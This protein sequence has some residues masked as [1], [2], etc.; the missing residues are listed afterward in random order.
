MA[1]STTHT[2]ELAAELLERSDELEALEDAFASST[3][4]GCGRLMLISGEAGVGKTALVRAFCNEQPA[5]GRVLWGACD[6]LFTPR[7]LGPFV[8][9][10]AQA[11]G[12]LDDVVRGDAKPYDVAG[13]VIREFE[14][15]GPTILVL[16]DLHWADEATLDVLTLLGR[17]IDRLGAT[18]VLA[19]YRDDE[20]VATHPLRIVVGELA[21]AEGVSALTV[22]PLSAQAVSRLAEPH[23]VEPGELHRR[24]GGN[25]F[26]VTEVL[27]AGG[28]KIP[29]SVRAAVL[30]RAGRLSSDAWRVLEAAAVFPAGCERWLLQRLVP[31][32]VDR[33]EECYTSGILVDDGAAVRFRHE[34]A[35]LALEET[36][37]QSRKLALHREALVA[38][39]S[40][41]EDEHDPARLA[42][43]AEGAG[44]AD[45]VLRFAPAA[46]MR[47]ASLGAHRE[48]AAQFARA[49]RFA[50]E[51]PVPER[52]WLLERRS[53]ESYLTDE[54]SD[55][56]EAIT[57][58]VELYRQGDNRLDEGRAV[59]WRS[60][61]LWCPGRVSESAQAAREAVELLET[62]PAGR[63]LAMAY[64]NL[65]TG[66]ATALMSREAIEWGT[67]SLR[68]ARRIGDVDAE[69]YSLATV[70]G[71]LGPA[72]RTRVEQGLALAEREGLHE[73]A[74]RAF[75]ILA[76]VAVDG[77]E[78]EVARR[79]L[80][81]GIAFCSERGIE[82][83][84]LYLLA[85][86]SRLELAE[87]RWEEAADTASAVLRIPRT[88]T[89]PRGSSR[90][91]CWRL[92]VRGAVTRT[93]GRCSTRPG[94]SP[95]PRTSC[96]GSAASRLPAPRRPGWR[97]I[98][99]QSST[100]PLEPS[101][102]RRSAARAGSQAS[103]PPGGEERVHKRQCPRS[104]QGRMRSSSRGIGRE[105]P[106]CGLALAVP[107]RRRWQWR[108]P[109]SPPRCARRSTASMRWAQA[110]RRRSSR[111]SSVSAA[112]AA[113]REARGRR[114]GRTRPG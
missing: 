55:A 102:S 22:D 49:L 93:S 37:E 31:G 23:G 85:D 19:T 1:A 2:A 43:H 20:L 24:T 18:V 84:R 17:R 108:T 29:D 89:T 66:Y 79:Y 39:T 92:S 41:P 69:A 88:S 57:R 114:R 63:E 113:C 4:D 46:A 103:L 42:H 91:P 40:A 67:R 107:T 78:H 33:L 96:H 73:R 101:S 7:P 48:A 5:S 12:E 45:A 112:S 64:G 16:E 74:A 32:E 98:I 47:A 76:L 34:L 61:I 60:Y 38:L 9:V 99:R 51:L 25:P 10:A 75:L 27:A 58:A 68:L 59:L 86:R 6:A 13:A 82:L 72:G 8:D 62:L 28:Q 65:A 90:C 83:H 44:D 80:E 53:Y 105:R 97:A 110:G 26:Y 94:L 100:P 109:T 15:R 56:I 11:G 52:A 106:R 14:A 71:A 50:D 111:G 36:I 104:W 30:A 21:R 77:H 95:N 3:K 70:G 87:G 54:S 81:R 35:R